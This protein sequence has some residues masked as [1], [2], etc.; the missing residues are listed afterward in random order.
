MSKY[1]IGVD[2]GSESARALL[3]NIETGEEVSSEMME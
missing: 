2:Y 3:L 1:S